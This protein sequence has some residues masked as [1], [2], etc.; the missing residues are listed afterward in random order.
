M[1]TNRLFLDA[2]F[3][4]TGW[5][6]ILLSIAVVSADNRIY[7]AEV[8]DAD[9]SLASDWVEEHVLLHLD[10][11]RIGRDAITV[12]PRAQIATELRE[13][14]GDSPEWWAYMGAYDWV[15]I[16]QLYGTLVDRPAGWPFY[17]KDVA[18]L[19]EQ[20]GMSGPAEDWLPAETD[21]PG[22]SHL[23]AGAHHAL[24]GA[25]WASLLWNRIQEYCADDPELSALAWP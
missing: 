24:P 22:W 17:V 11:V 9:F 21:L 8:A 2:E 1:T 3:I 14:A 20:A 15:A 16:S 12:K 19:F 7:Y 25:R 4:D 13:F 6:I 5:E 10:R 23:P 18:Q